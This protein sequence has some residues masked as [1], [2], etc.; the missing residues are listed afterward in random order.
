MSIYKKCHNN[1]IYISLIDRNEII[2][3]INSVIIEDTCIIKYILVKDGFRNRGF[4]TLLLKKL[5]E[6]C[7]ECNINKIELDD[8][9]D[10]F[11]KNNNIYLKNNFQYVKDGFPEMILFL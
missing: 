2:G 6:H 3:D 9:S 5:I 8:M 7:R 11:G 10:N 4:G 1:K